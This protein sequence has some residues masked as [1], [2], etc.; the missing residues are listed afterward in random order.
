M[1][2]NVITETRLTKVEDVLF[3]EI[4][5]IVPLCVA[6]T[7]GPQNSGGFMA[8]RRLPNTRSRTN[9]QQKPKY[10]KSKKQ[11]NQKE[12]SQQHN[13]NTDIVKRTKKATIAKKSEAQLFRNPWKFWHQIEFQACL[14][15]CFFVC[16]FVCLLLLFLLLLFGSF[17]VFI[18]LLLLFLLVLLVFL[19]LLEFSYCAY[20]RAG[21]I[22]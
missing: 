12:R 19:L 11:K 15:H 10:Q 4:A 6:P 13:P 2:D 18:S 7:L 20:V 22:T 17:R 21:C 14:K 5:L 16:L 1:G 9:N 3:P 8:C